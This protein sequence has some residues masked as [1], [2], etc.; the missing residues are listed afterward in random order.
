MLWSAAAGQS[1]PHLSPWP[2]VLQVDLPEGSREQNR[3]HELLCT[4][5]SLQQQLKTLLQQ[6]GAVCGDR[7]DECHHGG[8]GGQPGTLQDQALGWQ[9]PQAGCSAP[10]QQHSLGQQSDDPYLQLRDPTRTSGFWVLPSDVR[11]AADEARASGMAA[12]NASGNQFESSQEGPCRSQPVQRRRQR[13]PGAMSGAARPTNSLPQ[14]L[15]QQLLSQAPV[16]PSGPQLDVWVGAGAGGG[17]VLNQSAL[18]VSNHWGPVDNSAEVPQHR[19]GAA[20][21]KHADAATS[22]DG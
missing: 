14:E 9:Q 11:K 16:L 13:E 12:G 7:H 21:G 18:D 10:P 22:R 6:A 8:H 4:V 19:C 20:P 2:H 5:V 3:R 17:M 1:C 15:L